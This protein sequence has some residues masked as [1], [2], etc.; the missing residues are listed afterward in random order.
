MNVRFPLGSV[1]FG[2][3]IILQ[4][5]SGIRKGG[6]RINDG[7]DGGTTFNEREFSPLVMNWGE[8]KFIAGVEPGRIHDFAASI[9]H[10]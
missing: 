5:Q 2:R 8:V 3:S 9:S 10:I 6:L 1:I 7:S 4:S